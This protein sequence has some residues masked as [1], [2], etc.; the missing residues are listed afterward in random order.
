MPAGPPSLDD[1]RREID[2]I[3][4]RLHDLLME[5]AEVGRRIGE[6]KG[7]GGPYV[8]PG[9]EARI[10]RRLIARHQGPFPQ[11]VLV[12]LWREIVSAFS[13]IQGPFAVAASAPE[14]GPDLAPLARD[15]FGSESPVRRYGSAA[16][17]L[18]AV[19]DG[20]ATVGVLPLPRDDDEDPW[21]R[22]LSR[23]D[24]ARPRIV[25]RLPFA[26]PAAR[27]DHDEAL[28]VALLPHEESGEDRSY[29]VLEAGEPISRSSLVSRFAEAGLAVVDIC[30]WSDEP[31]H[32]LHLVEVEGHLAE[33][34][35]RLARLAGDGPEAIG[36]LWVVGGYA[37]PLGPAALGD[38]APPEPVAARP[39]E[40]APA[41]DAAPAPSEEP[42]AAQAE[43]EEAPQPAGGDA[44]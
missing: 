41:Q 12:R 39:C 13:A 7:D 31:V 28:A 21:W 37:V 32:R 17:V 3:D 38:P 5:R 14:G 15:H 42:A 10:L 16:G 26:A 19:T 8:R 27:S 36:Q 18:R 25:A 34:D 24:G 2:A 22:V 44:P 43:D 9:R 4:T 40:A 11:R 20:E 1:L 23:D 35:A 33:D 6:V 29:L 30:L